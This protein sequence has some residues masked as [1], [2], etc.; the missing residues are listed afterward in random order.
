MAQ[1][2]PPCES[3]FVESHDEFDRP[4]RNDR[5]EYVRRMNLLTQ[6]AIATELSQQAREQYLDDI[7]Q[8]M[9]KMEVRSLD[10]SNP[11]YHTNQP[12]SLTLFLTSPQLRFRPRYNG[13]CAPI[14]LTS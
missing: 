10:K 7:L 2:R 4:I 11:F 12:N 6:G 1:F 5:A 8:H 14:F 3:Y 13:S 9:E